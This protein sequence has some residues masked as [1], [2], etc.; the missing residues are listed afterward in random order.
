MADNHLEVSPIPQIV[1][2][3]GQPPLKRFPRVILP[4]SEIEPAEDHG[5]R[6]EDRAVD[7]E[8]RKASALT[9]RHLEVQCRQAAASVNRRG[10]NTR[11]QV[12]LVAIDPAQDLSNVG[13]LIELRAGTIAFVDRLAQATSSQFKVAPEC[14][15]IDDP[16]GR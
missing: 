3:V 8:S 12:T 2:V 10:R 16:D 15:S 11:L 1:S 7:G 6:L 5:L 13:H 9:G 4:D 14:K